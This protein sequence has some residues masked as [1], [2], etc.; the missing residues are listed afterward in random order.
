MYFTPEFQCLQQSLSCAS[1][2]TRAIN[3]VWMKAAKE[4]T[5][6]EVAPAVF[7]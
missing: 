2:S 6:W 5:G 3:T 1:Q 4:D 7:P